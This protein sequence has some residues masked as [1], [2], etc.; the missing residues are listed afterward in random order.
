MSLSADCL[1]VTMFALVVSFIDDGVWAVQCRCKLV[2]VEEGDVRLG[3][4]TM[5][6]LVVNELDPLE[7]GW[8]GV[9]RCG[10]ASWKTGFGCLAR[11]IYDLQKDKRL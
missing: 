2:L 7:V 10:F 5:V 9:W 3:A 6:F 4:R 11:Q 8:H 1:M